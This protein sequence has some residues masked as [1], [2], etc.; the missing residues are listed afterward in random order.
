MYSFL[1]LLRSLQEY[2]TPAMTELNTLVLVCM[3][4]ELN[5]S[6]RKETFLFQHLHIYQWFESF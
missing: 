4:T 5:A 1:W 2:T 6:N 3:S